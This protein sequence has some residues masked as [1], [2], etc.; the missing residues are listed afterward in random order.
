MKPEKPA[1]LE[2]PPFYRRRGIIIGAVIVVLLLLVEY[3][4]EKDA[5]KHRDFMHD[6]QRR[7]D[8]LLRGD[9]DEYNRLKQA[10]EIARRINR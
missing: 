3:A 2:K 6:S 10:D 8:A 1:P 9:T 7:T 4:M 5:Q